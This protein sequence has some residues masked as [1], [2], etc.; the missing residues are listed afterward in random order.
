MEQKER[1]INELLKLLLD[2]INMLNESNC[3]GLCMLVIRLCSFKTIS[4]IEQNILLKY[5]RNNKPINFI[6]LRH[7]MMGDYYF[8]WKVN[9]KEPRIKWLKKHIKKT[10]NYEK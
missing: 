3:E 1:S 10:E 8:Y 2:N 5:I 7:F 6:T 9:S 4:Y